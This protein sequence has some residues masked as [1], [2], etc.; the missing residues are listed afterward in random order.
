MVKKQGNKFVVTNKSG[1]KVLGT[2]KTKKEANAQ[3]AAIEISKH[4]RGK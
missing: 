4:K 2:H 1:T 3:L